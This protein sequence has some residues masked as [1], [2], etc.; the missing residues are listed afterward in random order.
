MNSGSLA[1]AFIDGQ[2]RR[3][4]ELQST[5]RSALDADLDEETNL[6]DEGAGGPQEFEDDAQKLAALEVDGNLV[7]RHMERLRRVER[8][9]EK[10]ANGTYGLSDVSGEPIPRE[11]LEA[12]PEAVCT[13]SEE[14]RSEHGPR[15]A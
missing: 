12:V 11:R 7:E 15:G 4:V 14:Q 1:A 2:R 9:L 3:L 6:K 5:L 10:I 13:L 8:A